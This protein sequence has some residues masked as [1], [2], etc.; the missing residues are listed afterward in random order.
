MSN[1]SHN[2]PKLYL[3]EHLSPRLAAQLRRYG[4]DAV[5]SQEAGK[6]SHDDEAQLAWAVSEQRAIVTF[7][8]ADFAELHEK[9]IEA[10]EEHFGI[11][12]STAETVAVLLHRLLRLLNTL[13]V[14]EL[15]NQIRWLN[16][17]K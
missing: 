1:R 9:Y 17:F 4:F 6:L 3:N 5:S 10:G 12:L 7:N 11:I 8:F 14:D 15:K 16:E 2:P 13:S